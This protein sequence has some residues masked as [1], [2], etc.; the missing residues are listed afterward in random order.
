[1]DLSLARCLCSLTQA[2]QILAYGCIT[3]RQHVV[4]I[5]YLSMTLT[6]IWLAGGILSEFYSQFLSFFFLQKQAGN[7]GKIIF[8][9][10]IYAGLSYNPPF[11]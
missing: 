4:N 7:T 6:Y 1:M 3:M 9:L 11:F 8:L 2:Y 5:F 10:L